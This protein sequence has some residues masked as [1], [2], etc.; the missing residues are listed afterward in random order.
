MCISIYILFIHLI[1]T[2]TLLPQPVN[3]GRPALTAFVRSYLHK[4]GFADAVCVSNTGLVLRCMPPPEA[5]EFLLA[6]P[7]AVARSIVHATPLLYT[8]DVDSLVELAKYFDPGRP[9]IRAIYNRLG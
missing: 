6:N 3:R 5:I 4:N 9:A 8:L 1:G 2:W 7:G